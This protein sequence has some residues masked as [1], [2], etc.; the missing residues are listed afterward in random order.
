MSPRPRKDDEALRNKWLEEYIRNDC[1]IV[2]TCA[3]LGI[4]RDRVLDWTRLYPR[5]ATL[6]KEAE[7][8]HAE[9]LEHNLN[10]LSN[11]NVLGNIFL[12]KHHND[13][14]TRQ[15]FSDEPLLQPINIGALW[16]NKDNK[17]LDSGEDKPKVIEGN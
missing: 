15:R 17:Q 9:K 2:T 14:D 3:Q 8:L 13:T 12:L 11:N 1:L 6:K 5:F 4:A 7:K 10:R 16:F